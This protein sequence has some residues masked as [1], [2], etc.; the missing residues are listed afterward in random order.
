MNDVTFTPEPG[1]TVDSVDNA[2]E[3][4]SLPTLSEIQQQGGVPLDEQT[5]EPLTPAPDLEAGV[6]P[7]DES[8]GEPLAPAPA[9]DIQAGEVLLQDDL[10]GELSPV[11]VLDAGLGTVL[12]FPAPDPISTLGEPTPPALD[13]SPT[14]NRARTWFDLPPLEGE[15]GRMPLSQ[16]LGLNVA[17]Q[18]PSGELMAALNGTDCEKTI[19]ISLTGISPVDANDAH[20]V[21]QGDAVVLALP[22]GPRAAY[23]V[24]AHSSGLLN[25][26]VE[27]DPL[28]GDLVQVPPV[29]AGRPVEYQLAPGVL[30]VGLELRAL[31]VGHTLY[32]HDVAHDIAGTLGTW[33][34]AWEVATYGD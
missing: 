16:I 14:V 18:K 11:Q 5:G 33:R 20:H 3:T 15:L 23:V 29:E 26:R 25:L 28:R 31:M 4:S 27:L 17:L 6:Q 19:M 10:T 7:L 30:P 12:S 13:E 34:W 21:Y 24:S 8:T 22:V 9:L 32:L 2:V 1:A